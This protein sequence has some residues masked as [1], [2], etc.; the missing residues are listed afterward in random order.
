MATSVTDNAAIDF[1]RFFY[2]ALAQQPD[3]EKAVKQAQ[4]HLLAASPREAHVPQLR[5][6]DAGLLATRSRRFARPE[7]R[8]RF[9]VD[10]DGAP[11]TWTGNDGSVFV[12]FDLYLENAPVSACSVIYRLHES[13]NDAAEDPE[14]GQFHEVTGAD[15]KFYLSRI[16]SEDDYTVEAY[17]RWNDGRAKMIKRTV[18]AALT[19]HYDG[20]SDADASEG[21]VQHDVIRQTIADLKNENLQPRRAIPGT[22][23]GAKKKKANRK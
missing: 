14:H 4:T 18:T 22:T 6:G 1:S 21:R 17:V 5:V 3:I 11:D 2:R 12:P 19:A 15:D 9:C 7:I 8:A 20:L 13:Y 10:D 23:R 16:D